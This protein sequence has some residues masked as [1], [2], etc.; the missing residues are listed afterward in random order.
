MI[1]PYLYMYVAKQGLTLNRWV[2]GSIASALTA[3]EIAAR[4]PVVAKDETQTAVG[5]A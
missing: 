5:A 1:P 2:E 3:S 4:I